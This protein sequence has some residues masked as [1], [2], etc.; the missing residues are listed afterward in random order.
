MVSCLNA[1]LREIGLG[2]IISSLGCVVGVTMTSMQT[3][4]GK[5]RLI[6]H[7]HVEKADVPKKIILVSVSSHVTKGCSWLCFEHQHQRARKA[8]GCPTECGI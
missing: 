6:W 5:S 7:R 8:C 4:V 1:C 3:L 2:R